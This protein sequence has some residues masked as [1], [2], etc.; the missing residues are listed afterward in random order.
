MSH[1]L[2]L[3]QQHL[4][5]LIRSRVGAL[6]DKHHVV[7]PELSME[8][9]ASGSETWFP[10]PGM[11]GG[12]L[13][14]FLQDRAEVVLQSESWNRIAWGSGQRHEVTASGYEL[15]EEGFV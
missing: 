11:Y 1:E 3:I 4:H 7:L 13:L 15:I 12:F 6:I 14:R 2:A 5:A 10:V 9:I 8:Q